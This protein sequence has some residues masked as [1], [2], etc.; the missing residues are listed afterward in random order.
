M[1]RLI[2]QARRKRGSPP[3][4]PKANPVNFQFFSGLLASR[5]ELFSRYEILIDGCVELAS[6]A[7]ACWAERG[8]DLWRHELREENSNTPPR[9]IDR[10]QCAARPDRG[11]GPRRSTLT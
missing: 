4:K 6:I 3:F 5:A 2:G 9:W 1:R 11:V 10:D 7:G 8:A